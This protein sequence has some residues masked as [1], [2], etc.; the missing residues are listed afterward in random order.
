MNESALSEPFR[1]I[2]LINIAILL[3]VWG[4]CVRVS[5]K[6]VRESLAWISW[7]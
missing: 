1:V 7:E 5:V 3:T 4:S 6:R 2:S